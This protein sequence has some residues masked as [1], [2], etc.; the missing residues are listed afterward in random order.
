MR[1]SVVTLVM[2][3]SGKST[4]YARAGEHAANVHAIVENLATGR[5]WASRD[6]ES[7]ELKVVADAEYCMQISNAAGI[8]V[9]PLLMSYEHA[10]VAKC[11][12]YFQAP[13]TASIFNHP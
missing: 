6:R 13:C 5:V 2:Y 10:P 8:W 3:R 4:F 7:Y 11:F 9:S 12:S 1:L